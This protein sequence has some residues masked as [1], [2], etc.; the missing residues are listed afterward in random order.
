MRLRP[1]SVRVR[2]T[3]WYTVILAGIVLALFLAVFFSVKASL[4]RHLDREVES[5]FQAIAQGLAEE[6][7]ELSEFETEGARP[8]LP[9]PERERCP[10]RD[11]GVQDSPA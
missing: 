11:P 10:L 9:G 3:L 4:I 5:E 6:P 8:D 1:S 7:N 2:L